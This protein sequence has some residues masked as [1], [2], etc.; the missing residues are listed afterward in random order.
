MFDLCKTGGAMGEDIGRFLLKQLIKSMKYLHSRNV[1]HRDL[2]IE[3]ILYDEQM[4]IKVADFGFATYKNIKKLKSYRGTMTYMAPEIKL[5]KQYDGRQTDIFSAGVILFIIVQGLFPFR[6]AKQDEFFYNLLLTDPVKY[7]QKVKGEN[8]SEEFKD[9]VV[10]MLSFNGK[11]RPTI[12]QIEKHPWYTQTFDKEL[13]RQ[14][15]QDLILG[16]K[17]T[18]EESC[19]NMAV[20]AANYNEA[21]PAYF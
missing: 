18:S 12:E 1:V 16:S 14:K 9:L 21:A 7:F 20:P 11:D 17:T 15:L 6:E 3:N 13:T 10:R 5:G 2:K 19:D 4:N 8:L